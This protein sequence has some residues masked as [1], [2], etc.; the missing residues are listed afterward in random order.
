MYLKDY[1]HIKRMLT[2][3]VSGRYNTDYT[4]AKTLGKGY[5]VCLLRGTRDLYKA[6][7]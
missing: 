1:N 6:E 3:I 7:N 2:L 5:S 4:I